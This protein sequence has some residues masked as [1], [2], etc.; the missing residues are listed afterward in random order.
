MFS[1]WLSVG[2]P[3]CPRDNSKSYGRILMIFWRGEHQPVIYFGGDDS[4]HDAKTGI[5]FYRNLHYC[6]LGEFDKFFRWL[7]QLSTNPYDYFLHGSD[8]SLAANQS[9]SVA[10]RIRFQE[11]LTEFLPLHLL[12][13]CLFSLPWRRLWSPSAYRYHHLLA[14]LSSAI[15]L[16]YI[17]YP[18]RFASSSL[19]T[20]LKSICIKTTR[21]VDMER[22]QH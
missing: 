5:F 4:D 14:L 15:F 2:L 3:V 17:I 20:A 12:R 9:I 22:L 8:V 1:Y 18:L 13:I 11:F 19:S 6:S 21:T 16:S 7:G 10:I